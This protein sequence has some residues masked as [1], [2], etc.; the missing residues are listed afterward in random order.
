[1]AANFLHGVETVEIRSGARP[2]R[3]VKTAIVG[4]V[5]TAPIFE[6]ASEDATLNEPIQ[7][8]NPTAAAKYFGTRRT[9]YTIP[10]ALDALFDKGAGAAVVINVFDPA[11]HKTAVTAE[12]HTFGEDETLSIGH[13]GISSLV[14]KSADGSTTYAI[15]TDYTVDLVEGIVTR[16]EGGTIAAAASVQLTYSYADP[17]KVTTADIIGEVTVDGDRTGMQAFLDVHPT[18]GYKPKLL[19]APGYA[20]TAAVIAEGIA[21]AE[22]L[23]AFFF[24]DAPAGTSVSDAI[25]G[26]GVNGSIDFTTANKRAVLCYPQVIVYDSATDSYISEPYSQHVAGVISAKDVTDGYWFSPSNSEL[27]GVTGVEVKMTSDYTDPNSEVNMLNEVGILTVFTGFGTGIRTWGNRSAAWPSD[28]HPSNFISVQRTADVIYD[29][30][31]QS[32]LPFLDK[33]LNDAAI[34]AVT[35]SVNAFLRTLIA[36]GAILDGKCWYDP[37]KNPASELALGHVTFSYDFM[38]PTPMERMTFEALMNTN[39]LANLGG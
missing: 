18:Y 31:E 1:M 3:M 34:D 29:S 11:T 22:K 5:G 10:Q 32:M 2:I 27:L 21:K 23:R 37:A 30:I 33:P 6:V 12:A 35:E 9:G 8:L 14:V 17:S 39:Y 38:P 7:I 4:I 20:S 16:V 13:E 24:V 15:T 28:T 26:R 36:R 25:A 19:T